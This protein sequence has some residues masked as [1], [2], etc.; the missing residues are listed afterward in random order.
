[1]KIQVQPGTRNLVGIA[2]LNELSWK[3]I[4]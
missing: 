4:G 1:M 2:W 3:R